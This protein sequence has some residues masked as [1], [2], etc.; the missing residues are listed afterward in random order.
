MIWI[1]SVWTEVVCGLLLSDRLYCRLKRSKFDHRRPNRMVLS[2]AQEVRNDELQWGW[3][4]T[5][6]ACS[7]SLCSSILS[8]T[9]SGWIIAHWVICCRTWIYRI[10]VSPVFASELSQ[11]HLCEYIE[12]GEPF[13]LISVTERVAV[14]GSGKILL[15]RLVVEDVV[16]SVF[17]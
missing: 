2:A 5:Q 15:A 6:L 4:L 11:A 9:R 16:S 7:M 13:R 10:T 14:G 17:S 12:I 8:R 3:G 1:F